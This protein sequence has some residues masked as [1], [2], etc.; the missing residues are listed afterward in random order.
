[1]TDFLSLVGYLIVRVAIPAA[2]AV[3]LAGLLR[4]RLARD[5]VRFLTLLLCLSVAALTYRFLAKDTPPPEEVVV[6][7]IIYLLPIG[8]GVLLLDNL[9]GTNPP[10]RRDIMVSAITAAVA[11]PFVRSEERRVGKECCGTCRSRWAPYH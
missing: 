6:V 2:G 7:T 8:G 11:A 4:R 9:S 10:T 3:A 1:M 5:L